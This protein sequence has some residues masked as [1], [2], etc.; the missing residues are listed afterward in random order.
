MDYVNKAIGFLKEAY[1]EL[2]KVSWLSRKEVIGSTIVIIIF[3]FAV[4]LYV[5][6]VD[7]VL[8]RVVGAILG[9]R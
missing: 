4:A 5:G 7:F 8:T 3:I 1:I 9:T 6:A 2:K